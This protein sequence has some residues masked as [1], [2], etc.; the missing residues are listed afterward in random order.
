MLTFGPATR[1]FVA[2][3]ATDLR[4]SF[5][6]LCALVEG[7]LARDAF[8]G[9]VFCFFNRRKDRLKLLVWDRSGFWLF[10][11]RLEQGTFSELDAGAGASIEITSR[12][13]LLLL[14]GIDLHAVRQRKRY[15][16]PTAA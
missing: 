8:S 1:I 14:E 3:G 9:H 6:S 2:R 12:E 4:K 13:L 7:V 5:D 15:T 11:R 10:Y 16:R